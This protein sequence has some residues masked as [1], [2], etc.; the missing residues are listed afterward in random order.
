MSV[1]TSVAS[2]VVVRYE[3]NRYDG[4]CVEHEGGR[5]DLGRRI[6]VGE[7]SPDRPPI[8]DPDV[9]DV[10]DGF[11]QQRAVL[12]DDGVL[13]QRAV[14]GERPQSEQGTLDLGRSRAGWIDVDQHAGPDDPQVQHRHEAL[15]PCDDLRVLAMLDQPLDGLVVARSTYVLE[16]SS[17]HVPWSRRGSGTDRRA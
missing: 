5:P 11:G 10:A 13:Q 2:S 6:G 12:A 9:A 16:R 3:T 15:A 4:V 8:T 1:T 17:D 14:P 7:A